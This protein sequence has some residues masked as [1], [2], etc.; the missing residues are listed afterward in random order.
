MAKATGG[1]VVL[2]LMQEVSDLR[3]EVGENAKRMDGHL[4]RIAKLLG[5]M[6]DQTRERFQEHEGRI[7]ALEHRK[8]G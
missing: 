8:L 2:A 3:H 4:G 1:D 5:K 6:A 7:R